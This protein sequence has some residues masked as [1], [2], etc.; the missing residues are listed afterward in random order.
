VDICQL[1]E[2]VY[3][4]L[5]WI[6]G[7]LLE[8][9]PVVMDNDRLE[10]LTTCP[11]CETESYGLFVESNGYKIVRCNNCN[12]L[13]VNPRPSQ[14]SIKELFENEYI[15][16]EE[17]VEVDFTTFREKSLHREAA[18]IKRMLPLGGHLLD[19]GAASGFFLSCFVGS[20]EWQVE[21]VEPSR[22]AAAAAKKKYGVQVHQGFL[23]E[24][25]FESASFDVVTSLDSFCFHPDPDRDLAE[26]A[27]IIKDGGFFCVEI[28]GL[29][30]RLMKNTGLLARLLYGEKARLNAGVHLFY[31]S[32][33]TLGRFLA[34]HGFRERAAFPEQS[35]LYGNAGLLLLNQGYFFAS[36]AVYRL[37]G[38]R[39]HYAPKEF[40]VY[41]KNGN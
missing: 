35:P 27:R 7:F 29:P 41:Q 11:L 20:P 21:G 14:T 6:L 26:I 9:G 12:L 40:L 16:D 3:N 28:P 10:Y 5:L 37:T 4:A 36:G 2:G 34:K 15:D 19:I 25:G 8:S 32:R 31:Y 23:A 39:I 30:F 17:R 33:D 13:F 24:Q 38:G 22:Y 18:H 1:D